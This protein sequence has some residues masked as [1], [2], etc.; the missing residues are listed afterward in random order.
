MAIVLSL[1]LATLCVIKKAGNPFEFP[2]T[3][4]LT[5]FTEA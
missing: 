1:L 3:W 2:L 4:F 5:E